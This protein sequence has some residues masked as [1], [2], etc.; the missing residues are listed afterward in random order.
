LIKTIGDAVML[1]SIEAEPVLSVALDLLDAAEA[2]GD[3]FPQLRVGI[4]SGEVIV[5]GGDIYGPPV[6]LAGRLCDVAKPSSVLTTARVHEDFE[7]VARYRW[8]A[9]GRRRFKNIAE[10][11]EGWRLRREK[12]G[13]RRSRKNRDAAAEHKSAESPAGNLKRRATDKV[14]PRAKT[15]AASAKQS[16]TKAKDKAKDKAKSAAR[17]PSRRKKSS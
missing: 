15:T 9:A 10:P 12:P 3:W 11:V 6:N 2:E 4:A 7:D 13:E 1:A 16:A 14:P 8:S 17:P 5:R